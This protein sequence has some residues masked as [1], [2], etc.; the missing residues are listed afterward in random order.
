M[1][2]KVRYTYTDYKGFPAATDASR[3]FNASFAIAGLIT[4]PLAIG[5]GA[6]FSNYVDGVIAAVLAV[7]IVIG[8]FFFIRKFH[9]PY[10]IKYIINSLDLSNEQK[11]AAIHYFTDGKKWGKAKID[12]AHKFAYSFSQMTYKYKSGEITTEEYKNLRKPFLQLVASDARNESILTSDLG[13]IALY[14]FENDD[15]YSIFIKQLYDG[16]A[17]HWESN[18][19]KYTNMI[20]AAKKLLDQGNPEDAT[21]IYRDSL[22]INPVALKARYGLAFCFIEMNQSD[23]AKQEILRM[24]SFFSSNHDIA[25]YYRQLGNA[26]TYTREY[27]AAYACYKYSLLFDGNDI[28]YRGMAYVE[29]K[30]GHSFSTMRSEEVL[31]R[32]NYLSYI[33]Y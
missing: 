16:S 28:A 19:T 9:D 5:I 12:D 31:K 8:L 14:Y 2:I 25:Y 26:L 7:I 4:I 13:H 18:S 30:A 27:E 15:E 29:D 17:F 20:K 10:I 32:T 6:F 3:R 21:A 22:S 23:N 33:A 11:K 24:K 1:A